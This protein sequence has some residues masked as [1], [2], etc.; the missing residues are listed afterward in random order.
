LDDDAARP[1]AQ[2]MLTYVL[3]NLLRLLHPMMPF[4]TE[5]IWQLL[6]KVAPQRGLAKPQAAAESIMIANWPQADAARRNEPIEQQMSQFQEILRSVR[7]I[8]SKQNIPPR[9][10]IEFSVR[11]DAAFAKQ[12]EPLSPYFEK[13]ANAKALAWASDVEPPKLCAKVNAAGAEVY[14]DLAGFID[15]EKEKARLTKEADKLEKV[16]DG[17]QKKLSNEKF[18]ANAPAEVVEKERASLA[19]MQSQLSGIRTSLADLDDM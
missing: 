8:R 4:I 15:V 7:D 6:G 3:D 18:V 19:E 5:E 2:R 10:K 17:K 14:V 1:V 13:L 12:V 9:E 16:I 11:C